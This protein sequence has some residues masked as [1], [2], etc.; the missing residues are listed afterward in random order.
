MR[1]TTIEG[2]SDM[3]KLDGKIA[4][5]TGGSSG[6]GLAIAQQFVNEGAHVFITGRR[7]TELDAAKNEIGRNVTAIK[8][9]VSKLSD[10]DQLFD[11]I[12]TEK[13]DSISCSQMRG[14]RSTGDSAR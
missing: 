2:D 11:Q 13:D 1:R 12:K 14:S 4:L 3:G 5:V 8:N 10:L 9:D 6:I 7:E